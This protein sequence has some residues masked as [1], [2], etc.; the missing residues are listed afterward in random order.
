MKSKV[1]HY[2]LKRI[3][4][5]CVA[6]LIGAAVGTVTPKLAN[7]ADDSKTAVKT[8]PAAIPIPEVDVLRWSNLRL[9]AQA[10]QARS[11]SLRLE[12]ATLNEQA[13]KF[14]AAKKQE[15]CKAAGVDPELYDLSQ[16]KDGGIELILKKPDVPKP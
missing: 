13:D 12:A 7:V 5:L 3:L 14:L 4:V 15:V 11:D 16:K 8:A 9:D 2:A 1:F 10:R 6:A